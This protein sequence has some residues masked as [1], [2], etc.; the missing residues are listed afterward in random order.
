MLHSLM[1]SFVPP[2]IKH[3]RDLFT[4]DSLFLSVG[5]VASLF[6]L[7]LDYLTPFCCFL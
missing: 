1:Q 5:K 3:L 2:A 7:G 4:E 6:P